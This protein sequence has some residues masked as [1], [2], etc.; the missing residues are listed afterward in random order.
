MSTS[1][2]TALGPA[3]QG[4]RM[5]PWIASWDDYDG[6]DLSLGGFTGSASWRVNGGDLVT[7]TLIVGASTTTLTW[8][9]SDYA[10]AGLMAGE[11]AVTNSSTLGPWKRAFQRV[12]LPARGAV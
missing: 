11:L 1:T 10:T 8:E 2:F 5:E 4:E 6:L 12:I 9:T 7:R 3:I